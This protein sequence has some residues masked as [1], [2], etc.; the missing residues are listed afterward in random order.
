MMEQL[1]NDLSGR[2][3]KMGI[4]Q[5]MYQMSKCDMGC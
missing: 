2:G 3:Q 1:S 4:L 5:Q